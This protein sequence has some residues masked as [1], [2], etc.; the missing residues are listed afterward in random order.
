MLSQMIKKLIENNLH[1][2]VV[3]FDTLEDFLKS[4][5]ELRC[6]IFNDRAEWRQVKRLVGESNILTL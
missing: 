6:A 1:A 3:V 5:I 4:N 2:V